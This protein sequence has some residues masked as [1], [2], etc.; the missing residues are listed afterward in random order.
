[1]ASPSNSFSQ[2]NGSRSEGKCSLTAGVTGHGGLQANQAAK[3]RALQATWARDAVAIR[4]AWKLCWGQIPFDVDGTW[5]LVASP[6]QLVWRCSDPDWDG[7]WLLPA[8]NLPPELA[9][10]A[11]QK[12]QE[13]Y[14]GRPPPIALPMMVPQCAGMP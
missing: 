2:W 3:L 9:T 4:G 12:W 6:L 10:A 14:L 8:A 7:P 5:A 1:M 11:I 13:L